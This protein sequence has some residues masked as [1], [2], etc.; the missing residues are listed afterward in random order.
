GVLRAR[1]RR[2]GPAAGDRLSRRARLPAWGLGPSLASVESRPGSIPRRPGV[3]PR[4]AFV[5]AHLTHPSAALRGPARARDRAAPRRRPR[6][7]CE[8]A[9]APRARR[10]ERFGG[11]HGA[12]SARGLPQVRWTSRA[13]VRRAR[14]GAG[15]SRGADRAADGA[16]ATRDTARRSAGPRRRVDAAALASPPHAGRCPDRDRALE[17]GVAA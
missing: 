13:G 17:R 10:R 1:A 15:T 6:L 11:S 5:L 16:S 2:R 14:T 3:V 7:R 8:A 12:R 4:G 9:A